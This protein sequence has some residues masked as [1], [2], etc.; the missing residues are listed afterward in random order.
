[1]LR[2]YN[3]FRLVCEGLF[4]MILTYAILSISFLTIV[5]IVFLIYSLSAIKIQKV[6]LH[7]IIKARLKN[8]VQI[9]VS[10]PPVIKIKFHV[11]NAGPDPCKHSFIS[12]N[13]EKYKAMEIPKDFFYAKRK[14]KL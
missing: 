8:F 7:D 14:D 4:E 9:K 11:S 3:D 6:E 12:K 10:S 2:K 5:F 1:M 13:I